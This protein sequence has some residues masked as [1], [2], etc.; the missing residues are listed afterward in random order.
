[1]RIHLE[2]SPEEARA[3]GPEVIKALTETLGLSHEPGCACGCEDPLEKGGPSW[4]P[5]EARKMRY[6]STQSLLNQ[7]V[8]GYRHTTA[9]ILVD[10]EALLR[11]PGASG[12]G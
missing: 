9:S 3:R 12:K 4:E 6:K 2:G 1:M 8:D 5:S 7:M 10:L 11:A